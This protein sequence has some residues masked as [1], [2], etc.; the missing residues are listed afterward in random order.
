MH[1]H[2]K[3]AYASTHLEASLQIKPL[4]TQKGFADSILLYEHQSN[5][6]HCEAGLSWLLEA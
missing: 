5:V 6:P 1:R 3:R 4:F 2:I